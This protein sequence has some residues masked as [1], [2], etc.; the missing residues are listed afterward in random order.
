MQKLELP[1]VRRSA[2]PS[3]SEDPGSGCQLCFLLALLL[4]GQHSTVAYLP[5]E[6]EALLPTLFC[7]HEVT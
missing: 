6:F 7:G 4:P 1:R 5:P 2:F 3:C